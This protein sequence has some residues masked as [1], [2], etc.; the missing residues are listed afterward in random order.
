[1]PSCVD[2]CVGDALYFDGDERELVTS[3][4]ASIERPGRDLVESYPSS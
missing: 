3:L 2:P 1:V 4:L